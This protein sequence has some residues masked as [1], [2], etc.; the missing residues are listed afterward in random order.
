MPAGGGFAPVEI[1]DEGRVRRVRGKPDAPQAGL[2]ACMYASVQLLDARAWHDLPEDGDI[3]EAA[4]LPWIARGERVMALVDDSPFVDMGVSLQ[5]YLHANLVL[6]RGELRWP[7]IAPGE[8]AVLDAGAR[9]GKDTHAAQAVVA[10]GARIADG[11]RL[12][13]VVAWRD[14]VVDRDLANAI[15]TTRGEVVRV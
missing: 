2:R 9:W 6:A 1:D 13:R 5:G 12:E 11:V 3:V 4:W 7:G 15:V 10:Q 8:G 14:A